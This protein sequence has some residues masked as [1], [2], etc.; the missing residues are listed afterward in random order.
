MRKVMETTQDKIFSVL[1]QSFSFLI[2]AIELKTHMQKQLQKF[3]Q[4]KNS[5]IQQENEE[6]KK[7]T[8]VVPPF[9]IK[10][11]LDINTQ[12]ENLKYSTPRGVRPIVPISSNS[13]RPFDHEAFSSF[14]SKNQY[15]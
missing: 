5:K 2:G 6:L 12:F 1:N 13:K 7:K 4:N 11:N 10:E 3:L 9:E 14:F 8:R 15:N